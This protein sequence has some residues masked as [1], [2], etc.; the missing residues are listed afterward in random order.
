MQIVVTFGKIAWDALH[1]N[2]GA[3]QA[4]W[5]AGMAKIDQIVAQEAKRVKAHAAEMA[6]GDQGGGAWRGAGRRKPAAASRCR[7]PAAISIISRAAA[8]AAKRKEGRHEPR[9]AA[10]GR[11]RGEKAAWAME[12]DAQGTFQ[13]YSLQSEADFWAAAL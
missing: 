9:R 7:R 2:W 12:Q 13:Q 10:R 6:R 5:S 3:I 8:A 4:D 11:A 1:L